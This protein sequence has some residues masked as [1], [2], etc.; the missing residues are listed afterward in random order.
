[1]NEPILLTSDLSVG[2]KV[3]G[4]A[5]RT[6]QSNLNLQLR[7]GSFTALVGPNGVGK[8]TL[9]RTLCGLLKP[10]AGTVSL[11][12]TDL[13]S[14]SIEKR[15]EYVSIVVTNNVDT[16]RLTVREVVSIGRYAYS[17]WVGTLDER[18]E[19]IVKNALSMVKI[20]HLADRRLSEMSD[21][22]RQR[23]WIARALAQDTP[24]ILLDEPTSFLDYRNRIEIFAILK[25]LS[26]SGKKSILIST[27][28]IDL[29]LR[30]ADQMW[31]MSDGIVQGDAE[32]IRASDVLTE[33]FGYP[34]DAGQVQV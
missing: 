33:V 18:N 11:A 17:N 8:S 7:R 22:E 14:L 24:L 20:S 3:G 19:E 5:V 34:K 25:Q 9:L 32:A 4:N 1:M 2:Y 26:Q 10:L 27:H 13:F 16:S 30:Y 6:L 12:G 21:G 28:E 29:A 31:V 23:V 15:A